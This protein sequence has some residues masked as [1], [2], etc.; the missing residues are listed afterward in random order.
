MNKY[1]AISIAD[2]LCEN[3]SARDLQL[4]ASI[5]FQRTL[6]F[7]NKIKWMSSEDDLL[8]TF[9]YL[10][11]KE[12]LCEAFQCTMEALYSRARHLGVVSP[13]FETLNSSDL[14]MA[15]SLFQEGKSQEDILDLLGINSPTV[16]VRALTINDY[17]EINSALSFADDAQ[18]GLFE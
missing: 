10:S 13:T 9:F 14:S 12:E 4:V 2:E 8:S 18:M 11:S 7:K 6:E 16:P 3:H 1:K 17:E 15:L 5:L